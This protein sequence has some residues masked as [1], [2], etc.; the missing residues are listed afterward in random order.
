MATVI[1]YEKPGCGTNARQRRLLEAAGHAVVA[2]DLLKERW[3]ASRLRAFFG[4]MPVRQWFNP[5]APQV[6]SGEIDP[7]ALDEPSTLALLLKEPI[8]IRRP[9]I[10]VGNEL[11][12]G[13]DR[14]PVLSLLGQND[15]TEEVTA[16]L[17]RDTSATCPV[18]GGEDLRP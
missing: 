1:F 9:L 16:C 12:A 5:A 10:E 4:T 8:L 2:R 11:G 13:F 15:V 3:T 18:P 7:A 6:K 14:E 17:H